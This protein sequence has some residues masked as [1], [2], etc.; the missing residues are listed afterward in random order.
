VRHPLSSEGAGIAS[1]VSGGDWKLR[2]GIGWTEPRL[3]V[4]ADGQLAHPKH[5]TSS[6]DRQRSADPFARLKR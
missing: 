4:L 5:N 2:L 3:T 1:R 6:Q